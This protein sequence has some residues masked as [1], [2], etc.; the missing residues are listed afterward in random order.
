MKP[1]D[2]Q[3]Q[4]RKLFRGVVMAKRILSKHQSLRYRLAITFALP[5]ILPL[6]LFLFVVKRHAL[7]EQSDVQIM[8]AMSVLVVVLGLV[9]FW[10]MGK[11]IHTLVGEF[12]KIE[13]GEL[14]TVEKL[15]APQEISEL[16][17]I[18]EAF[19]RILVELRN[20]TKELENLVYKLSTLSELTELVSKIPNIE[21]VLEMVLQRTMTALNAKIGSIMLLDDHKQNLKIVAAKGLEMSIVDNTRIPLGEGISGRVVQTGQAV[22]VEDVEKDNRFQ[23]C[24]N[25][26]YET[27]SFICMP[28]KAHDRIIGVLNL[29]KRGDNDQKIFNELDMKFL[30]TLLSHISFA[31]ENARLFKEAKES[32]KKLQQLVKEKSLQLD[33]AQQQILQAAK[34][35]ALGEIVAGVAH[36]LNNPLTSIMGYAQLLSVKATDEK[37]RQDLGKI[38]DESVRAAKIVKSLLSFAR[39]TTPEKGSCNI[40]EIIAKVLQM[41]T[42]D[43][44]G[45]DIQVVTELSSDLPLIMADTNQIQQVLLNIVNNAQQAMSAQEKPRKLRIWTEYDEERLRVEVSDT[46]PGIEPAKLERIFDPF[47]TTKAPGKGT[48]LG[49]SISYGIVKAHDG[50]LFVRSLEGEGTTFIVELPLELAPSES[51][52]REVSKTS[53]PE[54]PIKNVLVI[55]DDESVNNLITEI[56]TEKGCQ[57]ENAWEGNEG[58]EKLLEKNYDLILCDLHMPGMDGRQVYT[59]AKLAKHELAERIV[60][61]TGGILSEDTRAFITMTGNICLR[62]PFAIESLMEILMKAWQ[63]INKDNYHA[64]IAEAQ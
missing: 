30:N 20:N 47:Y 60:F 55:E 1:D 43:L 2:I 58:L 24:N 64:K 56:L 42:Y 57:V 35:S 37:V 27:P 46:G 34:L 9:V 28:L 4:R 50:D 48:G 14:E 13:R 61:L 5:L 7:V 59:K 17:N 12:L 39:K 3:N 33:Q 29:S 11:Q 21:H 31:V 18:A 8:L 63:R 38:F 52:G 54:L 25:P 62:K 19:N 45:N 49:L 40:N 51:S 10:K 44:Q 15:D 22:L 23:R 26:K 6:L 16:V 41:C 32:A 36:E 53:E